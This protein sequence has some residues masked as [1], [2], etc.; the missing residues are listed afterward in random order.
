[1]EAVAT[2]ADYEITLEPACFSGVN[3]TC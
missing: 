3:S 2:K 1:M